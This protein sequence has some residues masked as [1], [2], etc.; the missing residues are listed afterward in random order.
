MVT[1][2]IFE[3]AIKIY[4]TRLKLDTDIT[5][6]I[7]TITFMRLSNKI[8]MPIDC[9]LGTCS[10]LDLKFMTKKSSIEYIHHLDE[11]SIYILFPN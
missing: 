4:I 6:H 5:H 3:F 7:S 11:I 1:E 10:L 8:I 2:L 9:W